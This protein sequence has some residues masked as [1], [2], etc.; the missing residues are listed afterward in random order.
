MINYLVVELR[1]WEEGAMLNRDYDRRLKVAEEALKNAE[2]LEEVAAAQDMLEDCCSRLM[3]Y[4]LIN[5]AMC[6]FVLFCLK[7]WKAARRDQRL[8][9]SCFGP[10]VLFLD[11]LWMRQ[12]LKRK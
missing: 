11:W 6:C 5:Y 2:S 7:D 12:V 4:A 10:A 9:S 1:R 3:A 8:R